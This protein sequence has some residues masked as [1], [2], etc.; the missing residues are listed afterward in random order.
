[1]TASC[2]TA[3]R[4]TR[5]SMIRLGTLPL[6]KPGIC[7]W[8]PIVLYAW[9][10]IG[11]SSANGTS[12]TSLTRVGLMVSTALFTSGTPQPWGNRGNFRCVCRAGRPQRAGAFQRHASTRHTGSAPRDHA[13]GRA[14]GHPIGLDPPDVGG[15][16]RRGN[17]RGARPGPGLPTQKDSLMIRISSRTRRLAGVGALVAGAFATAALG[18][19]A[20]VASAGA[21]RRHRLLDRRRAGLRRPPVDRRRAR[22]GSPRAR[23]AQE[24]KLYPDNQA[25]AY[26]VIKDAAADAERLGAHPHRLPRRLRPRR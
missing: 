14:R 7:T 4:P 8:A 10:S 20:G 22:P 9:S 16:G 18:S 2:T 5:W 17:V 15:P 21:A 1:M 24:P 26:G 11:F 6:R 19:G 3:P 13:S 25:N 12:T 23:P